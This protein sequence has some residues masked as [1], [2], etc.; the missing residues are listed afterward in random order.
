[1]PRVTKY[2]LRG[3]GVNVLQPSYNNLFLHD[4]FSYIIAHIF[5]FASGISIFFKKN[6]VRE[7]PQYNMTSTDQ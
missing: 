5:V 1:M 2:I 4:S 6:H 3:S 7:G